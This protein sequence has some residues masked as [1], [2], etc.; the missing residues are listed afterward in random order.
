M[1]DLNEIYDLDAT[2]PTSNS[3]FAS[4]FFGEGMSP[5]LVNNGVR[6]F[7][8]MV[9]R[10]IGYRTSICASV[11]C[12]IANNASGLYGMIVGTGVI[13]SF[14][15]VPSVQ[16]DPTVLRILR[17][18]SSVSVSHNSTSLILLGGLSRR[19]QPGDVQGLISEGKENWRELFYSPADGGILAGS[20]S[21]STV[22]AITGRT[23]TFD[24]TSI[25]A[26][27]I[28]VAGVQE[29][30]RHTFSAHKNG[31]NQTSISASA[32][33]LTFGTED[34]D[35]GAKYDATTSV[36][37][38]ATGKHRITGA[39]QFTST[40]GVADETLGVFLYKNGSVLLSWYQ[41]RPSAANLV[42][43]PIGALLDANGT[44]T[45]EI[46]GQKSGA[47]VGTINGVAS[48]TFIHAERV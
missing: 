31:S 44:D 12:N 30:P 35:V 21:L 27:V 5:S 39:V 18:Q 34:W 38:P 43:V 33:K 45:Y 36:W 25:S 46:Y 9:R 6:N 20:I 22:N 13:N 2:G 14:G 11:S 17:Y 4:A 40:N 28:N 1:P 23:V 26:S 32:R 24:A 8:S 41:S 42:S 3:N 37:T 10:T 29:F 19:M 48:E 7:G 16:A 47:G 15:T